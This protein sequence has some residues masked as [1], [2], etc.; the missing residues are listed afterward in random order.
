MQECRARANKL[1]EDRQQCLRQ[2]AAAHRAGAYERARQLTEEGAALKAEADAA[3][4]AAS[5]EIYRRKCVCA[6]GGC[7]CSYSVMSK[8]HVAQHG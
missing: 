6:E 7:C 3:Q 2:A 1:H 4:Q 5:N 8:S